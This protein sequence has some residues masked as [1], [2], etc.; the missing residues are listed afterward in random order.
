MRMRKL[1]VNRADELLG[2]GGCIFLA[3]HTTT[4][5]GALKP[6]ECVHVKAELG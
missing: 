3:G 6:L 4:G 5:F 2:I 1:P